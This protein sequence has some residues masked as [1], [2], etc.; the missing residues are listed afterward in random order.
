VDA[1]AVPPFLSVSF[2]TGS[3]KGDGAIRLEAVAPPSP[4]SMVNAWAAGAATS[5]AAAIDAA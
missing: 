2:L 1:A 5:I 3:L 4:F